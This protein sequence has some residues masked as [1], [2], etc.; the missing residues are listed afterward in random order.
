MVGTLYEL[1]SIL[2]S[3]SI[4]CQPLYNNQLLLTI[5]PARPGAVPTSRRVAKPRMVPRAVPR[6]ARL[7]QPVLHTASMLSGTRAEVERSTRVNGTRV[8]LFMSFITFTM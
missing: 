7:V 5:D 2:T 3:V 4:G 6:V 8:E 1:G